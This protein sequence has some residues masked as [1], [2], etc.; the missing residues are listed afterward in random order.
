VT[1]SRDWHLSVESGGRTRT[2]APP[3]LLGR[4]ATLADANEVMWRFFQ[5]HSLS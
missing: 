2:T 3:R 4:P 1:T 5:A